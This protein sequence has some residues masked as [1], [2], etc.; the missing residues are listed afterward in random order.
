MSTRRCGWILILPSGIPE[1]GDFYHPVR[2][3]A[4]A[5]KIVAAGGTVKLMTG[6][7]AERPVI[8]RPMT[9][10]ALG[11]PVTIGRH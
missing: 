4:A 11:G 10:R 5:Q 9:I 3:L 1:E 6:T 8:T 7:T 2:S